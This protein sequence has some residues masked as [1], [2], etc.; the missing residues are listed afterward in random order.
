[1]AED[2]PAKRVKKAEKEKN[3]PKQ[4][5]APEQTPDRVRPEEKGAGS[6]VAKKRRRTKKVLGEERD[7][8]GIQ[9]E[10]R[11]QTATED[12]PRIRQH[13]EYSRI[14]K[15]QEKRKRILRPQKKGRYWKRNNQEVFAWVPKELKKESLQT[16][17][18]GEINATGGERPQPL[19][20][21]NWRSHG[22]VLQKGMAKLGT[23]S[24]HTTKDKKK[25]E[26]GPFVGVNK[27]KGKKDWPLAVHPPTQNWG[28]Q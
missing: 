16:V 15:E 4:V 7:E 20:R 17:A 26:R 24:G 18:V 22:N 27:K 14:P 2:T 21:K 8:K 10:E 25:N 12:A 19:D 3:R 23:G 11:R 13:H 5:A 1:L 9:E 6:K 28:G